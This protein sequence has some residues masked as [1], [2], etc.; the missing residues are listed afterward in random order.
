MRKYSIFQAPFSSFFSKDL[1]VDVGLEW[2]GKGLGYLFLLLAVCW[3]PVFVKLDMALSDFVNNEAP[4]VV[5]QIPAITITNGQALVDVSQPYYIN[6]PDTN[7]VLFIID[8]TGEIT[9]IDNTK[10]IGLMTK[11]QVIVKRSEVETQT[12][13]FSEVEEFHLDQ[14]RVTGWLNTTKRVVA[15]AMYPVA[16]VVSYIYR[17]VQVLFYAAIGLAFAALSRARLTYT[18]VVRLTAVALTPCIL[19][20]TLFLLADVTLPAARL[21]YFLVAMGYLFFGMS[22]VSKAQ[23]AEVETAEQ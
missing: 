1:Y 20:N 16:L 12:F 22:A 19:L 15:P 14:D 11:T 7:V 23:A 6:V 3:I 10:A 4:K 8:T 2:G 17:V 13:S 18:E 9:S 5:S 21:V